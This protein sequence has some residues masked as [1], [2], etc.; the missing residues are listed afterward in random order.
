MCVRVSKWLRCIFDYPHSFNP[1]ANENVEL[2]LH[3]L[4]GPSLSVLV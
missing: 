3:Y 1:K 2:Y 4:S